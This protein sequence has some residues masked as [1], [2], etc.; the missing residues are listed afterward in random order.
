MNFSIVALCGAVV[1]AMVILFPVKEMKNS[2]FFI[3]VAALSLL[4][5]VY[6][7]RG[8]GPIFFYLESL[9]SSHLSTYFKPLIK[10]LG[11]TLICNTTSELASDLGMGSITG[12]VELA[13]KIAIIISVLPLFDT[14]IGEIERLV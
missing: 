10:I 12:K 6:S 13:G 3:A 1:G 2:Y 4:I 7:L 8:A 11:I 9:Y 14:L 5:T